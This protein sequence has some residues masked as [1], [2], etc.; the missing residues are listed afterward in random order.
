MSTPN[1]HDLFFEIAEE[2]RA[3][4]NYASTKKIK[5][6]D[7]PNEISTIGTTNTP[8]QATV[9]P[10]ASD[11][12]K[13]IAD[14]IRDKTGESGT[15]LPTDFPAKIRQINTHTHNYNYLRYY[16]DDEKHR[17]QCS[18]GLY[19]DNYHSWSETKGKLAS[20]ATCSRYAEYYYYC[21]TCSH[22][23]QKITWKDTEGGLGAHD[24]EVN[25]T[26]YHDSAT[27]TEPE[28]F[29]YYC[30]HCRTKGDFYE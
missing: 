4:K 2:I 24:W 26:P 21:Y 18:C 30:K 29:W 11:L 8:E 12:M 28:K 6:V 23:S 20:A 3:K 13:Q 17:N 5:P 27:C 22:Y 14:A 16:L 15:I 19:H 7:F 25:N 1:L 10:T 9:V